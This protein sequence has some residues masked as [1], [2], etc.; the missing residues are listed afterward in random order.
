MSVMTKLK[1]QLRV[2]KWIGTTPALAVCT[3]CGRQFKIPLTA[4]ARKLDAQEN[5]KM[6][7]DNHRCKGELT[8]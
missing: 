3:S 1:R 6:Q 8:E 5:L 7:F 2:I 4:M